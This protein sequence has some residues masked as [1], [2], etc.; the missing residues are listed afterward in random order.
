MVELAPADPEALSSVVSI[1]EDSFPASERVPT[2]ILAQE[3]GKSRKC[4]VLRSE[5]R[6]AAF[7]SLLQLSPGQQ[8]LEYMAVQR[9]ARGRGYG[10]RLLEYVR[11]V[12]A[13]LVLFEVED[14]TEVGISPDEL[15][16]RQRRISFYTARGCTM[17]PFD[18][19]YRPP[20]FDE[21]RAARMVLFAL[22][23]SGMRSFPEVMRTLVTL[24]QTAYAHARATPAPRPSG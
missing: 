10:T 20:S 21:R 23:D 4:L 5:G 17:M 12:G 13:D 11:S 18:I 16:A 3:F 6:V 14:P 1:Y 15:R 7:A 8:L 19:S 22:K 24:A 9:D 2:A